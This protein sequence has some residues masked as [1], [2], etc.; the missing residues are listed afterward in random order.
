MSPR[1]AEPDLRDRLDG[2]L[3]DSYP[4]L[5]LD[6][7]L[8]S[9]RRTVRRRRVGGLVAAAAAALVLAVGATQLAGGPR[10]TAPQP[11]IE[12]QP[13]SATLT[14]GA[15]VGGAGQGDTSYVVTLTPR[16]STAFAVAYAEK[17]AGGAMPI[18]GSQVDIH[19][20]RTTWG[21][22]GGSS[23]IIGLVPSEKA[24]RHQLIV[25]ADRDYGGESYDVEPIP[26]TGYSAFA[27]S[28]EKPLVG[29]APIR[30]IWWFDP[31][32]RPVDRIGRGGASADVDGHSLWLAPDGSQFGD[33]QVGYTAT[34]SV[35]PGGLPVLWTGSGPAS[36]GLH[37]ITSWDVSVLLPA[38]VRTGELQ[39]ADGRRQAF[40]A[41]PLGALHSATHCSMNLDGPT[42]PDLQLVTWTESDGTRRSAPAE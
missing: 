40:T 11:A 16:G 8:A 10:V 29:D 2:A 5:D 33:I 22:S 32:G 7:V 27:V 42:P 25:R 9:G 28:F 24:Q 20:R 1:P 4:A 21:H 31:D 34:T 41:E 12:Q 15:F 17:R 35:K 14:V 26:G 37:Q 36:P 38:G 19:D 3:P 6:A 39:F 23:F 13:R 18:A 30:D